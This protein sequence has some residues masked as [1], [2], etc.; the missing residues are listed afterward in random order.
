MFCR[1]P[2][3]LLHRIFCLVLSHFHV[4]DLISIKSKLV[5]KVP[6]IDDDVRKLFFDMLQVKVCVTPLK[7]FEKL[8]CL[9]YD[10]FGQVGGTVELVPVTIFCKFSD[11]VYCLLF[12]I[13]YNLY[14]FSLHFHRN[15]CVPM[16]KF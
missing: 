14:R 10:G 12:H 6:G 13:L 9:Y 7:A 4:D 15:L 16:V 8:C 2:L 3:C 11:S 1:I 5:Q